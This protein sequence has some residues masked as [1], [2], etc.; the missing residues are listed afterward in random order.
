VYVSFDDG[1]HWQSLQRNLPPVP[2]HDLVVKGNDL[3]VATHGRSFWILTDVSPLRQITTAK[4]H[5]YKPA[6]AYRVV[7]GGGGDGESAEAHPHGKNP[8]SGAV[9]YYN[10][11]DSTSAVT[12]EFTDSAGHL[13]RR[14]SS[15]LDSAGLADSTEEADS[16][17][18][19]RRDSLEK[20]G[21]SSDSIRKLLA[22]PDT[23]KKG[24]EGDEP[25]THHVPRP[26]RVPAKLG[27]NM[28]AWNM[29][30]PDASA[31]ENEIMWFGGVTGPLVPPGRY[32]VKLTVGNETQSQPLII[33]ND[34][35]SKAT[36]E[37]LAAQFAL[38][39]KIRER[40]SAADDGVKTIRNVAFQV[41]ND[42]SGAPAGF[43]GVALPMVDHLHAIERQLYQVQ[44]RSGQDPLNYPIRL[45][46]EIAALS[47]TVASANGRPT[48]PT[49]AV[50]NL[51]TA[52]L[53]KQLVALKAVLST[54]LPKVNAMLKAAG[55]AE[56]VPKAEEP[57]KQKKPT[58]TA[59]A[60]R[61]ASGA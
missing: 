15:Q 38:L 43:A 23:G 18:E 11:P 10:V 5:L 47:G 53:D 16:V 26:P 50:F 3:V 20:A 24:D 8:P 32:T 61:G 48:A 60:T 49:Y 35:R 52:Q 45:N 51:L 13:V 56:I 40:L 58:I 25:E 44:N 33:K 1:E 21:V 22:L 34:P 9:I 2:I 7:W 6:V 30:Y 54:D 41:D 19:V 55:R 12:M 59:S 39:M 28:F 57:P 4:L 36:A 17:K 37:G 42:T 14:L 31:F 27:L 46:N 29:R